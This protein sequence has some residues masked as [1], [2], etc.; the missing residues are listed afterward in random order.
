MEEGRRVPKRD[1]PLFD[2]RENARKKERKT[3]FPKK[4]V[5]PREGGSLKR[6]VGKGVFSGLYKKEKASF[7]R[8]GG[9]GEMPE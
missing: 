9:G 7:E 4:S 1:P 5:R 6:D 8:G 3:I 2:E